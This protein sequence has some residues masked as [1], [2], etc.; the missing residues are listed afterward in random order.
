MAVQTSHKTE[1]ESFHKETAIN[2]NAEYEYS[3]E[4]AHSG[5]LLLQEERNLSIA[6]TIKLHWKPLLYC[7]DNCACQILTYCA[8]LSQA[9]YRLLRP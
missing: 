7:E 3:D 4:A 2:S 5:A 6:K 1:E 8:D 9:L